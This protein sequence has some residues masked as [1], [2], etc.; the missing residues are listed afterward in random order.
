MNQAE[1]I[2]HPTNLNSKHVR[3]ASPN[4]N[5]K[6][7]DSYANKSSPRFGSSEKAFD[8]FTPIIEV[9]DC[10]FSVLQDKEQLA[11]LFPTKPQ[12]S[13]QSEESELA[14]V[15][16]ELKQIDVKKSKS[17]GKPSDDFSVIQEVD[18]EP[19]EEQIFCT[20]DLAPLIPQQT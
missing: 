18:S 3:S 5:D 4:Q 2:L 1:D 15:L 10:N 20:Q 17:Q 16:E 13:E 7:F 9:A 11:V 6:T 19:S 8:E 14:M 12:I